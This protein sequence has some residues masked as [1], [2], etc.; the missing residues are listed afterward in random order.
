M[1]LLSDSKY[2]SDA[3]GHLT[4]D[5]ISGQRY[6]LLTYMVGL[7]G[8]SNVSLGFISMM[9]VLVGSLSQPLFGLVTDRVGPRWVIFGG[10]VWLG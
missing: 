10:L 6:V 2:L 7:M 1:N 9:F 5:F 8:L 4:I 3:L